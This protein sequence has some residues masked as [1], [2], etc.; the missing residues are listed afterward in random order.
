MEEL[1]SRVKAGSRWMW[2]LGDYTEVAPHLEIQAVELCEAI[3]IKP[4]MQVL[5]VAA[6]N[7]NF[8][9]A[10]ARRSS[11]VTACDLSPRM[12]ELGQARTEAAGLDVRWFEADAEQLPFPDGGFDV[13]AS[14][15]GAM[16]A[17]QPDLVA[18]ELFR[19]CRP[20]GTVAMA[21]YS[22]EG[23]LGTFAQLLTAFS[24]PPAFELPS[25]F[26]WG[27]MEV[28]R[29]RFAGFASGVE[30]RPGHVVMSFPSLGDGISF[31]ERTNGPQLAL[32]T[33]LPVEG[34][35]EF[36][37]QAASLMRDMNE[38]SEGRLELRSSY[39]TVLASKPSAA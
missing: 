14:V 23:F 27:D 20:G 35:D 17:P 4:G 13:V 37:R 9:A 21:N 3:G 2:S 16:F 29:R 26:E 24:A 7:G 8:A 15:F 18:R 10:A 36:K 12:I 22:R 6:G 5:D 33:L 28:V 39:L 34:Y 19:V 31:W 32:R 11:I 38:S 30:L 1:L 25:P